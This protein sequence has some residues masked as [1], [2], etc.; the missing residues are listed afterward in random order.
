MTKYTIEY[1]P[2]SD[3]IDHSVPSKSVIVEAETQQAAVHKF[4]QMY[5]NCF[6]ISVRKEE[7]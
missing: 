5:N 6:Y 3:I 1:Y 7:E 4:E 2:S